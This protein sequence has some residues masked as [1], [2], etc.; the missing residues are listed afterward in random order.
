MSSIAEET[1]PQLT[2]HLF[3]HE[4]GKLVSA[5]T[6]V[7]GMARIQLA[8]DV[9]QEAMIRALQTWPYQGIPE[10]P[11]AWLMQTARNRALDLIRREKS[12]H[13]K[14]PEIIAS[15]D[16]WSGGGDAADDPRFE[17]EI[18]DDRLRLIFACC[19]PLIPQDD[20]IILA[21][22]T[23]CGFSPA[24]I[25]SAYLTTEVAIHKRLTR[26][27]QKIRDLGIPFEI[28]SGNDL[29][30]R[31]DGVM[32]ILYLMFNEGYKA[33]RGENLIREELCEEAIRLTRLLASHPSGNHPHTHALLALMLLNA[34][35][36]PGR[37]DGNGNILRL[38]D[39]DRSTWNRVMIGHGLLHLE[40]AT[41]GDQLSEYHLQAVIAASHATAE[42]DASTDW[43]GILARYD[44]WMEINNS[45]VIALNRAVALARVQGPEAGIEA[46]EEIRHCKAL[47]TYYLVPAVL[48]ELEAQ[49]GQLSSAIHHLKR[50]LE[51]S[52]VK[53]EQS[54]LLK[55]LQGYEAHP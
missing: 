46:I 19:H 4:A 36:I 25:A 8:E 30:P 13:E 48:A 2:E 3:R 6:G 29:A 12:Y 40:H 7:F 1:V 15:L 43:P 33:S 22:K 47:E 28:P 20:Q 53:T 54:F 11:A 51:L 50:A 35:R 21:L 44:Q 38:Q 52:E 10:N 5:L 14:Q 55:Q 18:R 41:S 32:K 9:V 42:D 31:L 49:R 39:Q 23:L 37:I 16:R 24:E 45:P 17:D 34:A 26:A 27:R